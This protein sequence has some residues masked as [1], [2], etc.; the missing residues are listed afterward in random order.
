MDQKLLPF[1][2]PDDGL[3][4]TASTG[5]LRRYF[6]G[7]KRVSIGRLEDAFEI[8]KRHAGTIIEA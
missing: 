5:I 2:L 8:L 6:R 7:G 3:A 1:A 4:S